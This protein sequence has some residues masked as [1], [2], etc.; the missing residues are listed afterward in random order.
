MMSTIPV[1]FLAVKSGDE[2]QHVH[3]NLDFGRIIGYV[4]SRNARFLKS[5]LLVNYLKGLD[6]RKNGDFSAGNY[7]TNIHYL[8]FVFKYNVYKLESISVKI[9][10]TAVL[11]EKTNPKIVLQGANLCQRLISRWK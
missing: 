11:K 5:G 6:F 7:F 1:L 10:M 9:R 8:N 4:E 3:L 2:I